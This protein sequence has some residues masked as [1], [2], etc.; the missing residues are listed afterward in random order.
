MGLVHDEP[1]P[2][3][4]KSGEFMRSHKHLAL[5]IGE[6]EQAEMEKHY[7]DHGV[8]V[9]HRKTACGDYEPVVTNTRDWAKLCESRGFPWVSG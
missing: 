5:L 1:K 6:G 8:H 9:T 2:K 4:P 7:A 3:Q